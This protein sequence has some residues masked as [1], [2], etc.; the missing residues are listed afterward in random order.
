MPDFV[1]WH[2]FVLGG[3]GLF[4]AYWLLLGRH[5]LFVRE[6]CFRFGAKMIQSFGSI[7][8]WKTDVLRFLLR[9]RQVFV[10]YRYRQFHPGPNKGFFGW[11]TSGELEIRIPLV[12]KFW[13]RLLQQ[14]QD[15]SATDE[16]ITKI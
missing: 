7:W 3:A 2:I 5:R 12:Q 16:I 11:Q 10:E 14:N 13:L 4:V 1:L 15:E 9:D 6:L 8:G